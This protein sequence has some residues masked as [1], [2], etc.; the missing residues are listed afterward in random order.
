M[1]PVKRDGKTLTFSDSSVLGHFC[2]CVF[3][4]L[5]IWIVV[6]L[7]LSILSLGFSKLF[8]SAVVKDAD[9][10]SEIFEEFKREAPG[11]K[12]WIELLCLY[13]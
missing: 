11:S 8:S 5:P 7:P 3:I 10:K 13:T 2:L 6:V 12:V 4:L 1:D 9:N